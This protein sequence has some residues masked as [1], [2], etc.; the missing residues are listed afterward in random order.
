[1]RLFT[2]SYGISN[3]VSLGCVFIPRGVVNF[4]FQNIFVIVMM[5]I[6]NLH[7]AYKYAIMLQ[8][9]SKNKPFRIE[10]D[11]ML[12]RGTYKWSE[13][14]TEVKFGNSMWKDDAFIHKGFD[15]Y[16]KSIESDIIECSECRKINIVA[17]H[18][19]GGVM[20]IL[21]SDLIN[22][23]FDYS[24]CVFTYGSP[25]IGNEEFNRLFENKPIYRIHN[26]N[27]I[28]TMIPPGYSHIGHSID[29]DFNHNSLV[30][31]HSLERYEDALKRLIFDS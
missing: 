19:L 17:G 6:C 22:E 18:S 13:L 24:P 5:M 9:M 21:T 7:N 12:F 16:F 3:V 20:A 29:L 2:F 23:Y 1:M 27:D 15:E 4:S 30:L 26:T 10:D 31:N 28:I 8:Y 25:R 11:I 14:W